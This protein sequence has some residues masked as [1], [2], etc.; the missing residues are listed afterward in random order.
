[1]CKTEASARS[2]IETTPE[3]PWA[4]LDTAPRDGTVFLALDYLGCIHFAWGDERGFFDERDGEQH[5][6]LR[7]WMPLPPLPID[8]NS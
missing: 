5:R 7:R 3:T 4:S 6:E 8:L 2:G 1:M